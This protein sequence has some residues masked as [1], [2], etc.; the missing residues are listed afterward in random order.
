M[1]EQATSNTEKFLADSLPAA[2]ATGATGETAMGWSVEPAD[3]NGAPSRVLA[4]LA[5]WESVEAHNGFR[6]SEAFGKN[7][8]SLRGTKGLKGVSVVHASFATTERAH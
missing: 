3:F 4:V 8:S 1:K 5:G 6:G 2:T 7:I